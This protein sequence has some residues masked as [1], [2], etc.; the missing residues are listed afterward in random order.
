MSKNRQKSTQKSDKKAIQKV[1]PKIGQKPKFIK[2]GE[3][4]IF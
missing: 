2:N 3:N 1:T 4:R